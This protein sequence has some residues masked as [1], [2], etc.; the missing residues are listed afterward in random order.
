M[1]SEILIIA[2]IAVT[3]KK[4]H[5]VVLFEDEAVSLVPL[6]KFDKT[7]STNASELELPMDASLKWTDD[8][9]YPV[10]LLFI[11][12]TLYYW[13]VYVCL[14]ATLCNYSLKLLLKEHKTRLNIILMTYYLLR[15]I[16]LG[17]N[18]KLLNLKLSR[19]QKNEGNY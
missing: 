18:S 14:K 3:P 15:K 4:T 5:V 10:Q 8:I 2:C 9:V 1:R 16:L 11:G 17:M 12:N 19:S 6:S 13:Q 7:V